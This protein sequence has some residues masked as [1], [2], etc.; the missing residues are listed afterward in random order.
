MDP[1][2]E[3]LP[4]IRA[5]FSLRKFSRAVQSDVLADGT[6]AAH[7]NIPVSQPA[8][9]SEEL[10][11]DRTLLLSA[12][13]KAADGEPLP[14]IVD[15]DG[16]S[17]DVKITIDADAAVIAYRDKHWRFPYAA[18]RSSDPSRRLATLA[19]YLAQHT[20]ANVER[21]QLEA[22]LAQQDYSDRDFLTAVTLLSASPESF[23]TGL[24]Q[25]A[26]TGQFSM[27]DLLP[28]QL[29]Y[30]N[31]LTAPTA[32][33]AT[34]KEFIPAELGE[35]RSA[36]IR[37]NPAHALVMMAL[38]FG[39]PN[40]VPRE[41]FKDIPPEP[42]LEGIDRLAKSDDPF[43]L[44]GAFDL[45]VDRAASDGRFVS[46]GEKL[47]QKLFSDMK[48]LEIAFDIFGAVFVIAT[49]Y[50]AEHETLRREPVFW[51]RLSAASHAALVLRTLG[52]GNL[53]NKSLQTWAFRLRGQSYFLSAFNEF[54]QEP[55]WRPDWTVPRFLIADVYGRAIASS[56]R[57]S[58]GELP[59]VWQEPIG[60]ARSWVEDH[61]LQLAAYF[62]AILEGARQSH[63]PT[64]HE[65][66]QIADPQVAALFN[67][68]IEQPSIDTFILLTP[69]I[70]SLGFPSEAADAAFKVVTS[71]RTEAANMDQQVVQAALSLA[72]D[73]AAQNLDVRLANLVA[74]ISI[75]KSLYRE[76]QKSFAKSV[77]TIV[78][79]AAANS[80]PEEARVTLARRLESLAFLMPASGLSNLLSLLTILQSLDDELAIHLGRA[81]AIARL[82]RPHIAA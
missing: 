60:A 50:L 44:C 23:A 46:A 36:R 73:I 82:G 67:Q 29:Q 34:L 43:A 32:T 11:I 45:C 35:E 19:R 62:P 57:F 9:L 71:L 81:V 21:A 8:Q 4:R 31:N 1:K 47:L 55:R 5:F 25:K 76:E 38:T 12:F 51:R 48:R 28:H 70:R 79:C 65:L 61:K 15:D 80:D 53:E 16:N 75:E 13:Q 69:I 42:M 3:D 33:S 37:C 64:I 66:S 17:L 2:P 77:F 52:V 39:S 6:I 58:A 56:Q 74:D 20:L 54:R 7:F 78:E 68:L 26:S 40:L 59:A 30:W 10:T 49:A 14:A 41:L 72:A 63:I 27:N 22:L 18:F 24:R